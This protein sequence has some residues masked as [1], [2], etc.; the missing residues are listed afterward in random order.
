[1]ARIIDYEQDDDKP[2]GVGTFRLDD[3][4]EYYLDDAAR[5]RDFISEY[6]RQTSE[7]PDSPGK[8][9]KRDE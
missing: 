7:I 9:G 3:G 5:A 4:S 6:E 2:F 8:L 1:M